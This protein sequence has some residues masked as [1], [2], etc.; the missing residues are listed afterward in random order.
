[1][2]ISIAKAA[3]ILGVSI[4]TLRR[5]DLEGKLKAERTAAGHRR[6][7]SAKLQRLAGQVAV[8]EVEKGVTAVY[9]R[10][11]DGSE[12]AQLEDQI[13]RLKLHCQ[14]HGWECAVFSDMA[15]EENGRLPGLVAVIKGICAQQYSRLLLLNHDHL[16]RSGLNLLLSLC[17]EC[18]VELTILNATSS[19]TRP[20]RTVEP[21]VSTIL[22]Q[23]P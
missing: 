5:W 20:I 19:R 4:T 11:A 17:G 12:T 6:Y 8:Q 13:Q 3:D 16:S 18:G 9:A 15:G 22:S 14:Q 7:D 23:L 2:K 21:L 10:V 1:M